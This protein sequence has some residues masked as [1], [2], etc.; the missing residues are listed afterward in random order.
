MSAPVGT[1]QVVPDLD[2]VNDDKDEKKESTPASNS[3]SNSSQRHLQLQLQAA[4]RLV[5]TE[6]QVS[7]GQMT[8][9]LMMSPRVALARRRGQAGLQPPIQQMNVDAQPLSQAEIQAHR[10]IMH[11][12]RQMST[13]Q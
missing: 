10:Q 5:D 13:P 1:L 9:V 8:P 6:F 2:E 11:V 12:Q 7:Q 4:K 3:A